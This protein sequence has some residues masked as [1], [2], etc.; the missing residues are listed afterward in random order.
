MVLWLAGDV[1]LESQATQSTRMQ[2][3]GTGTLSLAVPSS[4]ESGKWRYGWYATTRGYSVPPKS[5]CVPHGFSWSWE[6]YLI[7][8]AS[9]STDQTAGDLPVIKSKQNAP[10]LASSGRGINSLDNLKLSYT[11]RQKVGFLKWD[12]TVLRAI[13]TPYR[14]LAWIFRMRLRRSLTARN[15][16]CP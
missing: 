5:S 12:S 3:Q 10:Y 13:I 11:L 8:F 2:A 6:E 1:Y 16:C 9:T 4:W 14:Y 15:R 7:L